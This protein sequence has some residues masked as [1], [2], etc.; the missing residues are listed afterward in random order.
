MPPSGLLNGMYVNEIVTTAPGTLQ[1]IKGHK[2]FK[3]V[4]VDDFN[5][6][7]LTNNRDLRLMNLKAVRLN[8]PHPQVL[9]GR[10]HLES[11][12]TRIDNLRVDGMINGLV[13]IS[14][15]IH[16]GVSQSRANQVISGTKRFLSSVFVDSDLV[17]HGLVNGINL[18]RDVV[19]INTN[20]DIPASLNFKGPVTF[21][22]DVETMT[23]N[24]I[25]LSEEAVRR[26]SPLPQVITAKKGFMRGIK[27]VGDVT[28]AHKSTIDD[29]D[30]SELALL[31]MDPNQVV[32]NGPIYFD[33]VKITGNV[34]ANQGINGYP[35]SNIPKIIWLKSTPQEIFNPITFLSPVSIRHVKTDFVNSIKVPE[36]F[37]LKYSP[38]DQFV[39][40][41]KIFLDEVRLPNGKFTSIP[42]VKLNGVDLN[43][44]NQ[45]M[46][47]NLAANGTDP[48]HG[49]K[50]FNALVVKGN[51]YVQKVNNLD[52]KKDVMLKNSDQVVYSPIIFDTPET[53]M[54]HGLY[55]GRH[56]H[57]RDTMNGLKLNAWSKDVVTLSF[58]SSRPIRNKF[59]AGGISADSVEA[60][61][62]ISGVDINQMKSRVVTLNTPQAISSFKNFTGNLVFGDQIN[63]NYLNGFNVTELDKNVVRRNRMSPVYGKKI[64]RGKVTVH[65]NLNIS[66]LVNDVNI[67]H[68]ASVAVSKTRDNNMTAPMTFTSPVSAPEMLQSMDK[69]I[70][71]LRFHELIF[72]DKNNTLNGRITF[73]DDVTVSGHLTVGSGVVN[74]CNL[75]KLATEAIPLN[76]NSPVPIMVNGH[77]IFSSLDVDGDIHLSHTING[78]KLSKLAQE[79]VTLNTNQILPTPLE[80][81]DVPT[82]ENLNLEAP[83]N[84]ID[85]PNLFRDAVLK[86]E[87]QVISGRKIFTKDLIVAS[88]RVNVVGDVQLKGFINGVNVTRLS[89]TLV[90]KYGSQLI[91]GLKVFTFPGDTVFKKN[92]DVA[93]RLG[94]RNYSIRVPQDLVLLNS[95]NDFI[96]GDVTFS[97][98]ITFS[99]NLNVKG[100]IDG[101]NLT[102]LIN[103][104][105]SLRYD[106]EVSANLIFTNDIQVDALEVLQTI[107]GMPVSEFVTR[108]GNHVLKG[109][110]KIGKNLFISGN[111]TLSP[112][113]LLNGIHFDGLTQRL[114]DTRVGGHLSGQTTMVAPI[115]IGP[116]GLNTNRLNGLVIPKM[117]KDYQDYSSYVNLKI[118]GFK[119][120]INSH[121]VIISRQ[122]RDIM[123]QPTVLKSF[124]LF[125]QLDSDGLM[126][127]VIPKV[128]ASDS[129]TRGNV[130]WTSYPLS[131]SIAYW[132][133]KGYSAGNVKCPV[134]ETVTLRVL[135]TGEVEKSGAFPGEAFMVHP[136]QASR[137]Q[138][139]YVWSNMTACG[140]PS[141]RLTFRT[142]P[143]AFSNGT[144]AGSPGF[145]PYSA[146]AT[147][148]QDLKYFSVG[149]GDFVVM[150]IGN[151][152]LVY[153]FDVRIQ[154]WLIQ[155]DMV[156][157]N[158]VTLDVISLR[159]HQKIRTLLAVGNRL[160]TLG[161]PVPSIVYEW[162]MTKS[163]FVEMQSIYSWTPSAMRFVASAT[164]RI[165]LL[166]G[167]EKAQLAGIE[168]FRRDLLDQESFS[169]FMTQ[170]LNV[171]ELRTNRFIHIQSINVN[172]VSSIDKFYLPPSELYVA[173]GS[174][175]SGETI[176][177]KLRSEV[178]H[179]FK[180]YQK[181]P[182]PSVIDLKSYWSRSGDLFLSMASNEAGESKVF[183]AIMTGPRAGLR[184]DTPFNTR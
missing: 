101:I 75:Q 109:H 50:I 86:S 56:V 133:F 147:F 154:T 119:S 104:R 40:G 130:S 177:F 72:L 143:V 179:V 3:S 123:E 10:Y 145:A 120:K 39:T 24:G 38:V 134:H 95:D 152:I 115:S 164:G 169:S 32:L 158:A 136:T 1:V 184:P 96:P 146:P 107:N 30:V 60:E 79:V 15:L 49:T 37:V 33:Q 76:S 58:N 98:P 51:V 135:P 117:V 160:T 161:A 42:G 54:R 84:G 122:M 9:T 144:V 138:P 105:I 137:I 183:K 149:N 53:Q 41:E 110:Y 26:N 140:Q 114:I 21:E 162:E 93:G 94:P 88:G 45:N 176:L 155:Q 182:T 92:L 116:D 70:D 27:V 14:H 36:D 171:Y 151:R 48:I 165:F 59:F 97:V 113:S 68:L 141:A 23:V 90:T 28:M 173:V 31:V 63:V 148:I 112:T 20:Q 118:E 99:R 81:R 103:D 157:F 77:K 17:L 78:L 172:G 159:S 82:V 139:F 55:V 142:R 69:R 11:P 19:T 64:F 163:R 168:C 126:S 178:N 102:Q 89:Q 108:R 132:K 129:G 131:D 61:G 121:E 73:E 6:K 13:N 67:I 175:T 85:L 18:H 12:Y 34:M 167:N 47:R 66:G 25:D 150:S 127:S 181:L 46:V 22:G 71:G 65:T 74:G 44:F 16:Y 35:I 153:R 125:R 57:V 91:S 4:T 62:T 166:I 156:S 80:F 52:L 83:V 106:Q 128:I 7:G 180:E 43:L 8:S 87:V 124:E 29:V 2:R 111:L 100:L 170:S 5:V 174:K